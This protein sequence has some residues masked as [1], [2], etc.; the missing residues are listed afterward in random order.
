MQNQRSLFV[1]GDAARGFG[2]ALKARKLP[3]NLYSGVHGSRYS[4]KQ[5][6]V[7]AHITLLPPESESGEAARSTRIPPPEAQRLHG[8]WLH[9]KSLGQ[10][11]GDQPQQRIAKAGDHDTQHGEPDAQSDRAVRRADRHRR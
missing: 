9:S 4:T 8:Y 10:G 11:R 6:G 7:V 3:G 2:R 5:R 1:L